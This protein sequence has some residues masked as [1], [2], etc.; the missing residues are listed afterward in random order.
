MENSDNNKK[1]EDIYSDSA[2]DKPSYK[3]GHKPLEERDIVYPNKLVEFLAKDNKKNTKRLL[4]GIVIF[5]VLFLAGI[6]AVFVND[7]LNKIGL[8][9]GGVEFTGNADYSEDFNDNEFEA[10]HDVSDA[11]SLDDLLKKWYTNG[12]A[13]MS[14]KYIIN[15]LLIGIDGKNGVQNGGNSDSLILVSINKK[16][17]KI[18]LVSFMRDSR[19]YF[20]VNGNDYCNKINA[21]YARGGAA[22][23]VRALENN[24][25]IEIDYYVAVDF[26]TFPKVIDALGGITVEIQEY[27]QKYIN[28]TTHA[29]KKIPNYGLVKLDGAQALVYSRIRK[30][31]A[32]SDVSRTR[33]QRTVISSLIKS[34]K[35][36]SVGQLNNAID[37]LLPYLSTD[38]PKS[39]IVS[40]GA[41]ALAQGWMDF[42]IEQLTMPDEDSRLDVKLKGASQWV[43]DY[44]L[45]A[46]R[47]QTAVFGTTNIELESNRISAFDYVSKSN[48]PSYGSES[49]NSYGE[50]YT[51]SYYGET[52]AQQPEQETTTRRSLIDIFGN[53]T[54]RPNEND[55]PEAPEAPETPDSPLEPVEE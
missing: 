52:T 51:T 18:T 25:K 20:D 54:T 48:R 55:V 3:P 24:Y 14:Q 29:I 15:V 34:I 35:G 9:N 19:S 49:G 23:T 8:N 37:M 44:P 10:M 22:T 26:T 46:Q 31:D 21:S 11:A 53:L 33:R 42:D 40:Y 12:G 41:Q 6:A 32:D 4:V 39:K 47:V 45:A 5:L 1:F 7:K 16:T 38:C 17:E 2:M 36:A 50:G 30:S 43:V 28:R 27:E 13:K